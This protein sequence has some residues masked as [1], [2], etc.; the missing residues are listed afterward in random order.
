MF[1]THPDR[2]P[3]E[4]A[5]AGIADRVGANRYLSDVYRPAF[6]AESMPP[7]MQ[8]GRAFVGWIGGA[9]DDLLCERFA[10]TVGNDNGVR[11]EGMTLPIPADRHRC[12]AKPR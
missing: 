2:L 4:L 11:V 9:L 8:E 1:R 5:L 6:D 10:R 7:T 3:R 12:H